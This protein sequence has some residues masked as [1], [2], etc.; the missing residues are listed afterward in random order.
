MSGKGKRRGGSTARTRAGPSMGCNDILALAHGGSG[1]HGAGV[2]Q[3]PGGGHGSGAPS[4]RV[5]GTGHQPP[6]STGGLQQTR[7]SAA[8]SGWDNLRWQRGN[9][10][11]FQSG[12]SQQSKRSDGCGDVFT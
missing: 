8:R 7:E 9:L 10:G 12:V 3:A 1:I 11:Y 5:S 4:S 2:Q 6:S